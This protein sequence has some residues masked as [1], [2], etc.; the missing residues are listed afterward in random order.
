MKG[1]FVYLWVALF[2]HSFYVSA[3][4][5]EQILSVKAK[6][7]DSF[8]YTMKEQEKD[9]LYTVYEL[10]YPTPVKNSIP[11][12]EKVFAKYYLPNSLKNSKTKVPAVVCMHILGGRQALTMLICSY[13]AS[14][15]VPAMMPYM[16]SYGPR[17]VN[18]WKNKIKKSP[19]VALK[20]MGC[21]EQGTSEISRAYDLL[22]SRPEVNP[23]KISLEGISLG[24]ILSTIAGGKD[25]RFYKLIILLGGGNLNKIIGNSRET[26]WLKDK[27]DALPAD[28]K[29]KVKAYFKKLDPLVYAPNL[30]KKADQDRIMMINADCDEVIPPECSQK[31]AEKM[32]MSKKIEWLKGH[33]HYTAIAELPGIL[34]RITCFVTDKKITKQEVAKD[35]PK[36]KEKPLQEIFLQNLG[37]LL[38]DNIPENQCRIIELDADFQNQTGIIK[39]IRGNGTKFSLNC[40][41]PKLGKGALGHGSYPWLQTTKGMVFEGTLNQKKASVPA[42]YINSVS[43]GYYVMLQGFVEMAKIMPQLMEQHVTFEEIKNSDGTFTLKVTAKKKKSDYGEILFDQTRS[44]PQKITFNI[45]K[46]KG[47]VNIKK[48]NMNAFATEE[49]F[50]PPDVK[51]ITKVEQ[52]Q[53]DRLM[54]SFINFAGDIIK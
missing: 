30:T 49:L 51:N 26:L 46:Q 35:Q 23:A 20:F 1:C 50:L 45:K 7:G 53:L 21:I 6:N 18:G 10:T 34:D 42:E 31:L 29:A 3:G 47:T 38:N 33:G 27:I 44:V 13:L 32:N 36:A 15:G 37:E 2:L 14:Y 16:P 4:D 19:D 25:D 40:D 9:A 54:A 39:I 24:A 12:Q 48:W 8:S 22:A 28:K 52:K 41:I 17:D 43:K 11:T 5:K